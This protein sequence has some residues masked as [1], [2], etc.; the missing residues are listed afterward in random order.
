MPTQLLVLIGLLSAI[1]TLTGCVRAPVTDRLQVSVIPEKIMLPLGRNTYQDMLSG[2]RLVTNGDDV[3]TLRRVGKRIARVTG[4]PGY[5]WRFSLVD[6]RDTL[7]AWCLPGGKIAFY[8][9]ILPV[10]QNEAGMAFVMGHEVGHAT[11]HHGAERMSQ[12]LAVLG[13]LGALYLYMDRKSELTDQQKNLM[14][15]A[16]GVGAQVGFILPFSRKH[17]K[18]ADIIG[19]MYMSRAGY[20]PEES[21]AVWERMQAQSGG[22]RVPAFLSTHPSHEQRRANLREWMAQARK[23]HARN[24]LSEDTQKTLWR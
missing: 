10:L 15:G 17:E 8:T 5:G 18:E 3:G 22:G 11:A 6:D 24:P 12:Q 13:G 21:V 19:L 2:A 16:L 1:L 4:E 9:G 7:N 23:R 20:P 14:M